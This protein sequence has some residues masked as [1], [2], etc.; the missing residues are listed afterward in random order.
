MIRGAVLVVAAGAAALYASR[1]FASTPWLHL[2][3]K[4]V[5]VLAMAL[6]VGQG[7]RA[8]ERYGRLVL[9]GL[10]ACAAGDVLLDLWTGSF[11]LGMAAFLAGHALYLAAYLTEDR[12]P[13]WALALP[14]ALWGGILF[15]FVHP[16]LSNLRVPVAIYTAT[17]CAMMWRAAARL[18]WPTAPAGAWLAF[19]GAVLFAA[20]DS[21]IALHRFHTPLAL[22]RYPVII[23][24]YWL[25]QLGI[26]GSALT[27]PRR[28]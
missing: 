20:S 2:A 13:A 21:L 8:R 24:L 4:P 11:V 26:C 22:T 3:L 12:R 25:G 18:R 9:L 5:P 6:F 10:L 16:G 15:L 27:P 23:G 19:G 1:I 14:F 7:P 28:G 17:I